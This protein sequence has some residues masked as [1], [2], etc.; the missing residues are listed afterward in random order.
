MRIVNCVVVKLLVFRR[1]GSNERG[2][3]G[4][5]VWLDEV[6]C[7]GYGGCKSALRKVL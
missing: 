4:W 7:K 3:L 2:G 6:L 5:V 1:A